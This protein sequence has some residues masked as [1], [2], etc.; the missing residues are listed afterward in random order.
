MSFL[1]KASSFA[2][3]YAGCAAIYAGH[4]I[5][6]DG[7]YP[8]RDL[9][10]DSIVWPVT[11]FKIIRTGEMPYIQRRG[12]IAPQDEIVGDEIAQEIAP[13]VNTPIDGRLRDPHLCV[14]PL[15]EGAPSGAELEE[16]REV[17]PDVSDA[18]GGGRVRGVLFLG[19]LGEPGAAEVPA[20][21][22]GGEVSGEGLRALLGPREERSPGPGVP[23]PS[24]SPMR[25][26]D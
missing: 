4:L 18:E 23:S 16:P 11:A 22:S 6:M 12:K 26:D 1:S 25:A 15:D 14:R 9:L 3:Q 10:W 2:L 21:G 17:V 5:R 20:E 24:P 13:Q 7:E 19:R 8:T